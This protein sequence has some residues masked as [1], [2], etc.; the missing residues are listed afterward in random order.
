MSAL[1]AAEF[2][3]IVVAGQTVI[4]VTLDI[5]GTQIGSEGTSTAEQEVFDFSIEVD[6]GEFLGLSSHT[7]GQ[8]VVVVAGFNDRGTVEPVA[9]TQGSSGLAD[10]GN[11]AVRGEKVRGCRK[12]GIWPNLLETS[13]NLGVEITE[14]SSG[15][16]VQHGGILSWVVVVDVVS[17]LDVVDQT[18][19]EHVLL[20]EEDWQPLVVVDV[21]VLG[22]VDA[23]GF[24]EEQF[25]VPVG[26]VLLEVV[27]DAVVLT[28]QHDLH[29]GQSWVLVDT[30]ISGQVADFVAGD[31]IALGGG[32]GVIWWPFVSTA[33][34]GSHATSGEG[35][36]AGVLLIGVAVDH[37]EIQPRGDGGELFGRFGWVSWG[38]GV[39]AGRESTDKVDTLGSGLGVGGVILRND[40]W[41]TGGWSRSL[42]DELAVVGTTSGSVFL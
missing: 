36:N 15:V 1:E 6:I 10:F 27:G 26:V 39:F 21:V 2:T 23:A 11:E 7:T 31:Q 4:A 3:V 8:E 17:G 37:G 12:L 24:L 40:D 25:V 32:V 33:L 18:V 9:E 35:T 41:I 22:D 34:D 42:A 13:F 19:L 38:T 29:D 30:G 16:R 5:E 28:E 14:G 20:S